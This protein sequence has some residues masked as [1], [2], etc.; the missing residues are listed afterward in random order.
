MSLPTRNLPITPND[1]TTNTVHPRAL[2]RAKDFLKILLRNEIAY[3]CKS[4]AQANPLIARLGPVATVAEFRKQLDAYAS[5]QWPFDV[6]LEDGDTLG[7]W[8]SL[9]KHPHAR[10][11]AVCLIHYAFG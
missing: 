4:E 10:T 8:E 1:R 5:K 9:E 2:H 3:F 11:L 6:P 7:W